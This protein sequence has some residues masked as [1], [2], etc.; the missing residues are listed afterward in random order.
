MNQ[1][2]SERDFHN[3]RFGGDDVRADLGRWYQATDAASRRFN[4][5]VLDKARDAIVLEYGCATGSV[6]LDWLKLHEIAREVHGIDISNEAIARARARSIP[7]SHFSVMDAQ[8]MEYGDATFDL[9]FGRGILHHLETA[10]AL[11]EIRRVLK[12]SGTCVLLEPMGHNPLLNWYRNRTPQ[13]RTPDEHP[14]VVRDFSIARSLF[15][16]TSTE[17]FGLSTVAAVPAMEMPLGP[18]LMRALEI[19]DSALLRV[20]GLRLNAWV[21]VLTLAA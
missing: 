15:R 9:V 4:T 8:R 20:P 17:F 7:N 14:L 6:S 13:M 1:L 10:R 12:P 21:V 16:K 3:R 11:R 2:D 18:L 19:V 5:I